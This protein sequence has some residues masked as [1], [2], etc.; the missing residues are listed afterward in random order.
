MSFCRPLFVPTENK[1]EVIKRRPVLHVSVKLGQVVMPSQKND[2]FPI[3]L[4]LV[5]VGRSV[6]RG[7]LSSG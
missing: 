7:S 6:V 2:S 5:K 1:V 4:P 3:V